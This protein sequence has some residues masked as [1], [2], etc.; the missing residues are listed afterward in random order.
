MLLRRCLPAAILA[1]AL[2]TPALAQDPSFRLNNRSNATINEIYVSSANDNSWGSDLLGQNVLGPGQTLVI[3]LPQGQ[4]LNDIRVVLAN[5]QS[6]E[7]RRVD[8]CQITDYNIQ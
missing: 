1:L 6:H 4:C 2:A 8:T 7:R 3:R 5:G